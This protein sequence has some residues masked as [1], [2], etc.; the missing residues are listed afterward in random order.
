MPSLPFSFGTVDRK[1]APRSAGALSSRFR[2]L[3]PAPWSDGGPVG[4]RSPYCGLAI[5]KQPTDPFSSS[6]IFF[7]HSHPH[8]YSLSLLLS[9]LTTL[10]QAHQAQALTVDAEVSGLFASRR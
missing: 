7:S 1:S 5:Y 6:P 4:L 9:M 2:A 3:L 8:I 10:C